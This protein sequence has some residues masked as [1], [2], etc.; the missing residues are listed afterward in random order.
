[1]LRPLKATPRKEA[2]VRALAKSKT[3]PADGPFLFFPKLVADRITLQPET[4]LR[5]TLLL[6][7]T[8]GSLALGSISYAQALRAGVAKTHITPSGQAALGV[9]RKNLIGNRIS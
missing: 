6:F 9:V 2:S 1:V 7:V 8:L 3:I 4:V 5:S